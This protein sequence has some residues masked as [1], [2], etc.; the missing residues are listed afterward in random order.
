MSHR[1]N[2]DLLRLIAALQVVVGHA[3][4]FLEVELSG[5]LLV[6][7]T[8]LRWF[9]GV[10]VFFALS[11]YLLARSFDRNDDLRNYARNRSLRIFPALWV[12]F[13]ATALLLAAA[14][15]LTRLSPTRLGLFSIAQ[16]TIGQ[17]WIPSPIDEFGL[18]SPLTPNSALWTIRVEI[19]FYIALPIMILL[20]RRIFR[21]AAGLDRGL[22]AIGAVSFL[23][24][25]ANHYSDETALSP[26]VR[27]VMESPAPY[28][29]YF[30]I[31]VMVHRREAWFR[32]VLVPH[33]IRWLAV[34]LALRT[35][36]WLV[37]QRV[38]NTD[39]LAFS[40][41]ET[42]ANL[43]LLAPAFALGFSPTPLVAALKPR[44]DISYGVYLWHMV[45]L[46]AL[47][48]WDVAAGTV[49]VALVF[50]GSIVAGYASWHLVEQPALRRKK[51]ATRTPGPQL[52]P[53]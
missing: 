51:S 7:Y 47:V 29:W 28:L 1:N 30:I 24:G 11:G 26:L 16:L 3:V 27:L 6:A 40:A 45:I 42:V 19:G 9:P 53:T 33:T 25:I 12:C 43:L 17:F 39:L 48:H 4:D 2:F 8:V 20:G 22:L 5:P 32:S 46:N 13:A 18:G 34:F 14:G 23:I 37:F 41:A 10:P 36:I 15:L 44:D 49:A 21:S 50:F 35:V 31:G 52:S 38:D